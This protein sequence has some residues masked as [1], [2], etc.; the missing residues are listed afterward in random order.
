MAGSKASVMDE[1]TRTTR[2]NAFINRLA[3][4]PPNFQTELVTQGGRTGEPD[5]VTNQLAERFGPICAC[6]SMTLEMPYKD[7]VHGSDPDRDLVARTLHAARPRVSG[8]FGGDGFERAH[9]R[10]RPHRP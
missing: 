3:A 10:G 7:T 6:V 4:H 1:L 2:Y 8:D 5:H 9:G